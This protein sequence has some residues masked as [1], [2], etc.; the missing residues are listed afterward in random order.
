MMHV[1]KALLAIALLAWTG[2]EVWSCLLLR[3]SSQ[4]TPAL[5][6]KTFRAIYVRCIHFDAFRAS[7]MSG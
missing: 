6:H 1:E 2:S 4:A 3:A 7:D 5:L